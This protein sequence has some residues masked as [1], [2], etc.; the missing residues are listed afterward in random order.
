M[1][2][3]HSEVR[4]LPRRLNEPRRGPRIWEHSHG[5]EVR[6]FRSLR[7]LRLLS[8]CANC[9]QCAMRR[10]PGRSKGLVEPFSLEELTIAWKYGRKAVG[11]HKRQRP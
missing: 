9:G 8:G 7:F 3:R 6:L 1:D 2:L 4:Q 11:W 5:T 10:V